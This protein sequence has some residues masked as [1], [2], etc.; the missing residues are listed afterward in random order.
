MLKEDQFKDL[1][2][3]LLNSA[4]D[5]YNKLGDRLGKETDVASGMALTAANF[6]LAELTDKVGRPEDALAAHR[7]VLG[8]ARRW[9]PTRRPTARR[10]PTLAAA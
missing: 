8:A 6:E 9:R 2:D 5:F 1:R 4:A 3:R 10:R 7:A